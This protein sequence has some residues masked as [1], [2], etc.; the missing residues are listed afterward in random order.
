[1]YTYVQS[2]SKCTNVNGLWIIHVSG[3]VYTYAYDA[4]NHMDH[5]FIDAMKLK[6]TYFDL[7]LICWILREPLW[8][9]LFPT[10]ITDQLVSAMCCF[11]MFVQFLFPL[12]PLFAGVI[13][14]VLFPV[15]TLHIPLKDSP[16]GEHSPRAVR[17]NKDSTNWMFIVQMYP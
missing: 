17:A 6:V 8:G 12:V 11:H 10:L 13:L 4:L 9:E 16:I 5:I 1:M 15:V 14:I 7:C 2:Y 3:W